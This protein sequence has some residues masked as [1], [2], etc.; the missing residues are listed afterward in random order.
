[1]DL[2]F[3]NKRYHKHR[4]WPLA[5]VSRTLRV[6]LIHKTVPKHESQW[7]LGEKYL[8]S[9]AAMRS[10]SCT[11]VAPEHIWK[12]QDSIQCWYIE[13]SPGM[14]RCG[15][16][17]GV[18]SIISSVLLN[19][20]SSRVNRGFPS[21]ITDSYETSQFHKNFCPFFF[22]SVTILHIFNDFSSKFDNVHVQF[23][24]FAYYS[25][26]GIHISREHTHT[27]P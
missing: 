4:C 9:Q 24:K 5:H 8:F 11:S 1:M 26:S 10:F 6:Q 7:Q 23:N 22:L 20:Y 3:T 16:A 18:K 14:K 21:E 27:S 17:F 19:F 2:N 13:V 15:A 25:M 12:F